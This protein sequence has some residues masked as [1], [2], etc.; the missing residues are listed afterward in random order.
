MHLANVL[1]EGQWWQFDDIFGGPLA[2]PLDWDD[3]KVRCCISK[4]DKRTTP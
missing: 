4:I 1:I 3:I 2:H